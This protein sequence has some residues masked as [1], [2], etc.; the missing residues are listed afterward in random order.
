MGHMRPDDLSPRSVSHPPASPKNPSRLPSGL[1]LALLGVFATFAPMPLLAQTP[2]ASPAAIHHPH[3]P[4]HHTTTTHKAAPCPP[5]SPAELAPVL[6]PGIPPAAGPLQTSFALRYLDIEPGTGPLAQPGDFL[7]V[8]Y[9]G[10]LASDG[11]KFDSSL[12]RNQPFTFRQGIHRVITGWDQGFGGMHVGGKRR[13]F[14]P[15]QLAY[16]DE[17]RP[18]VIPAKSDLIFDIVLVS[19]SPTPPDLAP[20]TPPAPAT[21]PQPTG[22]PQQ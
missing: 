19:A 9:T 21:P 8:Q 12:D 14:I 3:H 17:G 15:Y 18:P 5:V 11:T 16:G 7:T 20:P 4:V 6:P 1:A 2:S 13:L 10:W 22:T